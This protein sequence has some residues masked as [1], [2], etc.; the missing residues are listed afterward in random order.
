MGPVRE[1]DK[2]S[3]ALDELKSSHDARKRK[4]PQIKK[5]EGNMA[6]APSNSMKQCC[7]GDLVKMP[8]AQRQKNI[9]GAYEKGKKRRAGENCEASENK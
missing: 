2:T 7:K 3:K 1:A 5:R 6:A 9:L 4:Q 8:N